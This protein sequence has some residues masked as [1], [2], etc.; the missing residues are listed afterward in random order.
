[1]ADN[2]QIPK[3]DAERELKKHEIGRED[4]P[5]YKKSS[6]IGS[7]VILL[8][9]LAIVG[10]G[11]YYALHHKEEVS[12]LWNRLTHRNRAPAQVEPGQ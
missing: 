12:L 5:T 10:M 7:Y 1:M 8:L 6:H 3:R 11:V 4:W 9:F 2:V